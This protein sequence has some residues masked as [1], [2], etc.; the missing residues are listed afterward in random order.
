MYHHNHP[1]HES[2]HPSYGGTR[3]RH[4]MKRSPALIEGWGR[5]WL[6]GGGVGVV[7]D[8]SGVVDILAGMSEHHVLTLCGYQL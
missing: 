8:D 6:G 2:P 3:H 1:Y 7:Y 4:E 5:V